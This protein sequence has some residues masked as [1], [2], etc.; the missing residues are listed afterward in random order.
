[1]CDPPLDD[2]EV[3]KIAASV[4]EYPPNVPKAGGVFLPRDLLRDKRLWGRPQELRL[5]Q[6]LL[7]NA[8]WTEQVCG[9]GNLGIGEVR[10]TL[11]TIARECVWIENN[12]EGEWWP[13]Q[14]KRLIEVLGTELGTL[15]RVVNYEQYRGIPTGS[16][17]G[18]EHGLEQL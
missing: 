13:S 5:F 16:P 4:A 15:I 9:T 17:R 3:A 12:G 1:M 7:I 8:A 14:V 6:Y 11:R 18:L 2:G 10:R